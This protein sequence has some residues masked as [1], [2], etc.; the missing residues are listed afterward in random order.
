MLNRNFT[1]FTILKTERLS[2]GR[3]V[4]DD[5]QDIFALRS[6]REI[7]KYLDRKIANTIDD[8]RVFINNVNENINKNDS[9]YWAITFSYKNILVGTVCLFSFS[10][11]HGKCEIC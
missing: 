5:E 10:Y 1:A 2:L 8:A 11:E 7:N 4:I 6:D 3:L 9:V